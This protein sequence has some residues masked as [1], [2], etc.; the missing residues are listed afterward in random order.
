[1]LERVWRKRNLFA[2]LVE[3]KTDTTTVVN[4]MKIP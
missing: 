1:M 2:L 3:M 4:I